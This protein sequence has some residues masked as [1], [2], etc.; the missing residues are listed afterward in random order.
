MLELTT[1]SDNQGDIADVID[2]AGNA[3]GIL[4]NQLCGPLGEN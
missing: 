2:L 1:K 4:I 3:L